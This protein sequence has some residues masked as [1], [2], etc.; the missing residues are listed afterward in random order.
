MWAAL[1]AGAAAWGEGLTL[2][3]AAWPYAWGAAAV[4]V[5]IGLVLATGYGPAHRWSRPPHLAA[6]FA[7]LLTLFG[8]GSYWATTQLYPQYRV[9]IERAAWLVALA[10]LCALLAGLAARPL[11]RSRNGPSRLEWDWFRV[12]VATAVVFVLAAAGTVGALSRIGYVPVLAGDPTAARV[13][14]P[15]IAG[16]WYRLSML[17]GVAALLAGAQVAARQATPGTWAIGLASLALV[18]VYGPRFFVT[19]PLGVAALLWDRVRAP[20]R[21][22]VLAVF[23]VAALAVLALLG[24]V[25]EQ[26]PSAGLLGPLGLLVYG[27][28]GEFRDLGW[29]LDHYASGDRFLGGVT[30]G[31]LIV[32]LLPR[33]FWALAGVDKMAVYARNSASILADDMGQ[34]T[35][36]RVGIFGECFMNFGWIGVLIGAAVYGGLLVWL[37]ERLRTAGAAEVRS[38]GLALVA[39]TA[40]FALAGQLN[41]FTSTLTGLGYPLAVIALAAAR[42]PD[43]PR[44]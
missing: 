30:L 44:L 15:D 28:F 42:R 24:Y 40:T 4:W 33:Q 32:P 12:R 26:D 7:A 22:G 16:L 17:G 29:M 27:T 41:M 21:V 36:Q 8:S 9:P 20:L 19:L 13:D 35:G 14:F 37:D 1:A 43:S 25:R 38:I 2:R 18:G 39:A 5:A 31:S 23:G 34:V 6:G 3:W 10:M 11:L